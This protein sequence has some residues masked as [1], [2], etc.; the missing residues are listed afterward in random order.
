MNLYFLINRHELFGSEKNPS[1]TCIFT[2]VNVV[3]TVNKRNCYYVIMIFN[4][5]SRKL[6]RD[7]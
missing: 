7:I 4:I 2:L 5:Y 6:F 1:S 3:N